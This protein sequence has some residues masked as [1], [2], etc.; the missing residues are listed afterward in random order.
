MWLFCRF[1]SAKAVLEKVERS[2][3]SSSVGVPSFEAVDLVVKACEFDANDYAE[4]CNRQSVLEKYV[5][6]C[7]CV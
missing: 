3:A 4:L 1:Y 6:W 2:Y 5:N 7:L